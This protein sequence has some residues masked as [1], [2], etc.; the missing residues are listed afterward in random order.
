[1]SKPDAP[2]YEPPPP[3]PDP[4]E[5]QFASDVT[6]SSK[7]NKKTGTASLQIPLAGGSTGSGQA[8]GLKY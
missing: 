8:S 5:F 2:K 6:K 4:A 7:K 1:M 3:P